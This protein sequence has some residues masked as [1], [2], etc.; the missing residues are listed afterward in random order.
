MSTHQTVAKFETRQAAEAAET[1]LKSA[2]FAD[3]E[4][5]EPESGEPVEV[6]P[7]VWPAALT[8]GAAGA[9]IGGLIVAIA[10]QVPNVPAIEAHLVATSVLVPLTG[11]VLGGAALSLITA[12]TRAQ[13]E[14][15]K[16]TVQSRPYWITVTT[17]EEEIQPVA[18]ILRNQGGQL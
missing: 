7:E 15:R 16:S 13:T 18:E 10:S 9:L 11:S 8:G 2:G 5:T 3:I 17:P 1:T 14:Q 12:L 4:I 6:K